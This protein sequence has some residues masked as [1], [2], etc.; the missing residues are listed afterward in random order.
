MAK[1]ETGQLS[2]GAQAENGISVTRALLRGS[3]GKAQ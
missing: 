3:P 2:K 1:L